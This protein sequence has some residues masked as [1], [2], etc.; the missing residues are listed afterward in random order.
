MHTV[1]TRLCE[2]RAC[3]PDPDLS[4]VLLEG[5]AGVFKQSSYPVLLD[6]IEAVCAF[7]DRSVMA[8]G[9]KVVWRRYLPLEFSSKCGKGV[10]CEGAGG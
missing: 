5:E 6:C 4:S 10:R 1:A 9:R 3:S 8:D 2:Q 7:H